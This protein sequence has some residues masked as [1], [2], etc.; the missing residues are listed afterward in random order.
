MKCKRC[1]RKLVSPESIT[2]G[3]G[4]ACWRIVLKT[5]RFRRHRYLPLDRK[6]VKGL[7]HASSDQKAE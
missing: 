4:P 1:Q 7:P 2:R 6:N 3:Y 5:K